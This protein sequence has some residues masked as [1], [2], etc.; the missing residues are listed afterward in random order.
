MFSHCIH[1]DIDS[2][3][4]DAFRERA[5]QSLKGGKTKFIIDARHEE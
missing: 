2:N 5:K 1:F 4:L 3:Q